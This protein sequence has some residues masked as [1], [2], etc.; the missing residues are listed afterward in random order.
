MFE[1][2]TSITIHGSGGDI[3]ETDPERAATLF[4][5][6]SPLTRDG[7]ATNWLKVDDGQYTAYILQG[8]CLC[9]VDVEGT[10]VP[11]PDVAPCVN[12]CDYD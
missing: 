5:Q 2:I 7:R 11:V 8:G 9:S 10:E 1:E 4:G 3:T 12:I 6:L